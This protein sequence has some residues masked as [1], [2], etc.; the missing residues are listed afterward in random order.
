MDRRPDA[1]PRARCRPRRSPSPPRVPRPRGRGR[2][3]PRPAPRRSTSSG[4]RTRAAAGGGDVDDL[5]LAAGAAEESGD[6]A[7]AAAGSRDSPIRCGSTS[8]SAH[9]RSR[10]RA[11]WAPRLVAA[12]AWISSTI[13]QRTLRRVSRAA[14]VS[15][16][17]SDSGVVMR[18]S[19]GCG[20]GSAAPPPGCRHCAPPRAMPGTG[21]PRRSDSRAIPRSGV[22][23]LRSTSTV[24]ARSGE[25]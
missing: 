6:L 25:T 16:R 13:T 2:P 8:V 9:S 17:K 7:R 3:C 22:R 15:R 23:R 18:M 24:S 10:L 14:L 21:R 12:T 4:P 11:R 5:D 1:P 20:R 19:G